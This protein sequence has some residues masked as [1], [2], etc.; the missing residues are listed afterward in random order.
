MLN[1]HQKFGKKGESLAAEHLARNGYRILKRN[2][3]AKTGEIDIIAKEG[4]T[5]VFVE[6]KS[7]SSDHFGSPKGAVTL[8]K[9]KK[10][11]ITALEYLKT[12]NQSS[13]KAR[14]DVVAIRSEKGDF[15]V[16]IIKNAFEL[17]C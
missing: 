8:K 13:S 10:I 1:R 14:F 16:E 7:R 11:S 6:V 12:T 3:R 9:Q 2:H 5:V 15:N 17:T 4:D